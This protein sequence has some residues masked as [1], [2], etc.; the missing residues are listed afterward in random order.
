MKRIPGLVDNSLE[1]FI[2]KKKIKIIK[3]GSVKKFSDLSFIDLLTIKEQ[4]KANNQ[5]NIALHDMHP[6]SEIRRIEQFV[7]CR[8]GGL[9]SAPDIKKGVLQDGE[10]HDCPMR[11]NCPH[12]GVICKLPIINN[13]RLEASDILLIKNLTTSKTN[14]VIALE[15]GEPL[16]TFHKIKK[17]LYLKLGNVQTKQEVTIIATNLNII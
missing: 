4:I 12:N 5:L 8:F 15:M 3:N 10:Y 13:T 6:S 2:F 17:L 9:D 7:R 16:G 11:N 1:F 14:D